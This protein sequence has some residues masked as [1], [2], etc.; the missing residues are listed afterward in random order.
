MDVMAPPRPVKSS[1]GQGTG[2][3]FQPAK[4]FLPAIQKVNNDKNRV[5]NHGFKTR[6]NH[7]SDCIELLKD[8]ER[9]EGSNNNSERRQSGG[10]Q[11]LC[12]CTF[13]AGFIIKKNNG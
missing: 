1:D 10:Q 8:I 11:V 3:L 12:I 5:H 6:W 4:K 9:T 2:V 13:P 7:C